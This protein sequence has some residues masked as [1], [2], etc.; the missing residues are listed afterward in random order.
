MSIS[1]PIKNLSDD[2]RDLIAD[3]KVRVDDPKSKYNNRPEYLTPYRICSN[4]NVLLPFAWAQ[5]HF[6]DRRPDR[7]SFSKPGHSFTGDCRPYQLEVRNIA[8]RNL[9]RRGCAMISCYPGWGKTVLAINLACKTRLRVLVLVNKIVL[10]KQWKTS[11][12]KFTTDANILIARPATARQRVPGSTSRLKYEN[13]FANASFVIMNAMNVPKIS[14]DL[15]RDIGCVVVDECHQLVS[16]VLSRSFQY[17][18]PRYLIGLSA[19]PYRSDG[20]NAMIDLYFSKHQIQRLLRKEHLVYHVET[21]FEPVVERNFSGNVDWNSILEQQCGDRKRNDLIVEV[22]RLLEKRKIMILTKRV[23]HAELLME[24]LARHGEKITGL[25]GKTQTFDRDARIL[26][27]TNSKI[28]VGFDHADLDCLILASDVEEYFIQYL[29]RV[30]RRQDIVPVI[31][32]FVDDNSILQKHFS[33]RMSVYRKHGG[34]VIHVRA[35]DVVKIIQ[36]DDG[37]GDGGDDDGDDDAS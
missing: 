9:N 4:E 22:V 35:E 34:R 13:K 31:I 26:I 3:L 2:E 33:T 27:G 19:T 37:D 18:R 16:K 32:D 7:Q 20:L 1:I 25:F 11:I 14:D 6:D 21:G 36:Q 30:F 5:T 29:G 8:L 24:D 17:L 28:G 15:L 23:A 12:E 10:M